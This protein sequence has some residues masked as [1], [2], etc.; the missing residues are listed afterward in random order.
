M[1]IWDHRDGNLMGDLRDVYEPADFSL[2]WSP[3]RLTLLSN[4]LYD[5]FVVVVVRSPWYVASHHQFH[6]LRSSSDMAADCAILHT[7][8]YGTRLILLVVNY[9][10]GDARTLAA[11]T[12]SG[13]VYNHTGT[14]FHFSFHLLVEYLGSIPV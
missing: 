3:R 5:P 6:I 1:R 12:S 2:R 8:T 7:S 4:L 13:L 14:V 10:I 11:F 9:I